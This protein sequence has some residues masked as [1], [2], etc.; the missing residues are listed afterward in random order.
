MKKHIYL[1]AMASLFLF[2]AAQLNAQNRRVWQ[3][4]NGATEILTYSDD[5]KV[6]RSDDR[7]IELVSF[8]EVKP[9]QNVNGQTHTLNIYLPP[10]DSSS[11]YLL[12]VSDGFDIVYANDD[13]SFSQ[14]NLELNEGVYHVIV[15]GVTVHSDGQLYSGIWIEECINLFYETD[16]YVDFT[17]CTYSIHSYFE[18]EN[19]NPLENNEFVGFASTCHFIW[20]DMLIITYFQVF[21]EITDYN[22]LMLPSWNFNGFSNKSMFTTALFAEAEGQKSYH[23]SYYCEGLQEDVI[24]SVTAEDLTSSTQM[25]TA[26]YESDNLFRYLAW[27]TVAS[28]GPWLM[29]ERIDTRLPYDAN[30][31]YTV[32]SNVPKETSNPQR[33]IAFILLPSVYNYTNL[34]P[35]YWSSYGYYIGSSLYFNENGEAI[36]EALPM[37]RQSCFI[38]VG[39]PSFPNHFPETPAMKVTPPDKTLYFGERTPLATYYPQ[40][41]NALN[42][43]LHMNFFLGGFFF[44][45]ENSCERLC[46]YVS[47]IRVTVGNYEIYNDSLRKFNWRLG[48]GGIQIAGAPLPVEVEVYNDYLMVEGVPKNNSTQVNFDLNR[49]DAMPPTTTFLR[50]LDGDGDEAVRLDDLSQSTL[51]F[52]CGDFTYHFEPLVNAYNLRLYDAKPSVEVLYSIEGEGWQPLAITEDESLFHIE[53]GN[54]FVADLSQLE[55]RALNKWVSLKFML[56]DAAGNTQEQTLENVFYAGHT[57]S[58]DEYA[59][60]RLEH[61]VIPNPFTDEVRI[62]SA[63]PLD[64]VARVQLY[65]VLGRRVYDATEN[66]H[67]VNEFI[68]DGSALKPGIYFYDINTEKGVMRGKIL[69]E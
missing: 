9:Q 35:D 46:D 59:A 4:D 67:A 26:P 45:G 8:R 23:I 61:E 52:G 28:K 66:G 58:V 54:V 49:D 22:P 19:G 40:A 33:Q 39:S 18:D 51:V 1:I 6:L 17:E 3:N 47:P 36:R 32:V 55:S 15:S 25:F 44:S 20:N 11:V 63:Q 29:D 24:F 64:G 13:I 69:K 48:L 57:I 5:Y 53:Y 30:Q 21:N 16:I 10:P 62:K 31:P 43:P 60:E 50:V 38:S 2:S 27:K 68:I 7:S 65:D 41:F 37:F 12:A 14:L 56:E 34:D 42:T